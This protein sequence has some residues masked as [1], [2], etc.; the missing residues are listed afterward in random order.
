MGSFWNRSVSA[1]EAYDIFNN[2]TGVYYN[3]TE[4][5]T[6]SL[7]NVTFNSQNPTDVVMQS[8]L[9]DCS[10]VLPRATEIPLGAINVTNSTPIG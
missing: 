1:Q 8:R 6:A 7:I 9:Y 4:P 2:G 3:Q 10:I 5:P